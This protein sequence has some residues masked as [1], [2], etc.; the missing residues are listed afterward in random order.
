M[1]EQVRQLFKNL[2][3][4][5]TD[6]E[7]DELIAK[8]DSDGSGAVEFEEFAAY[9]SMPAKTEP[10]KTPAQ[11][12]EGRP[13][14]KTDWAA[15]IAKEEARAANEPA[16]EPEPEPVVAAAASPRRQLARRGGRGGRMG[17]SGMRA[18]KNLNMD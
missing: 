2:G 3:R 1:S 18:S 6:T 10:V 14:Q 4:T 17:T 5:L 13:R 8:M 9:F 15:Q 12:E 16:P 11:S 7:F